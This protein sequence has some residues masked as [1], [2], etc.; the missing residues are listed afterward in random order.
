MPWER[1]SWARG[2]WK[3]LRRPPRAWGARPPFP[4]LGWGCGWMLRHPW[5]SAC[6]SPPSRP[7][8]TPVWQRL[9]SLPSASAGK[10]LGQ[11]LHTCFCSA[12]GRAFN[13]KKFIC[14]FL[15]LFFF[16][17]FSGSVLR[18][19]YLLLIKKEQLSHCGVRRFIVGVINS[20]ITLVSLFVFGNS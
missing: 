6:G 15:W 13:H 17:F 18:T 2:G 1:L 4:S 12:A 10:G 9:P 16:F 14:G 19:V 11:G 20:Y 7:P 5:V 3:G 8:S